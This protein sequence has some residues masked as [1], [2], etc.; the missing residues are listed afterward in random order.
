MN[1]WQT[2]FLLMGAFRVWLVG[3]LWSDWT[4]SRCETG[5]GLGKIGKQT[6]MFG[7]EE[8]VSILSFIILKV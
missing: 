1:S 7:A 3:E 8:E 6:H 2:L 5:P 4:A